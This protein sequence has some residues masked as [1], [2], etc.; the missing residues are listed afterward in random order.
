[1]PQKS[2]CWEILEILIQGAHL[3]IISVHSRP[4]KNFRIPNE[5][6][7]DGVRHYP[8]SYPIR[9]CVL[10]GKTVEKHVKNVN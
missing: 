3:E 1:M 10:C 9:G 7:F 5:I 8:V 6:R 4:A 2:Y